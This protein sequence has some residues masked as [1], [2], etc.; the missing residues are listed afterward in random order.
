MVNPQ[1]QL[2]QAIRQLVSSDGKLT[3]SAAAQHLAKSDQLIK[4]AQDRQYSDELQGRIMFESFL[5]ELDKIASAEMAA[6]ERF[7]MTDYEE[8]H[9][10]EFVQYVRS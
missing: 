4:L 7:S 3:K 2:A 9:P 10:L 1:E 8:R 5:D 6:G